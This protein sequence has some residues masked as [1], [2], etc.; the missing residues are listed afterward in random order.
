M[1]VIPASKASFYEDQLNRSFESFSSAHLG[2]D[3]DAEEDNGITQ[4]H[5]MGGRQSM[6]IAKVVGS[7]LPRKLGRASEANTITNVVIG[8]SVEEAAI[9]ESQDLQ[10]VAGA[11]V[12]GPIGPRGQKLGS[13]ESSLPGRWV[14]RVRSAA[15]RF[16]RKG[17]NFS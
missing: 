11:V 5:I 15:Q 9:L 4:L 7:L 10:P 8:V 3:A 2:Q 12:S 13:A 1:S 14:G 17:T 6:S 16:C